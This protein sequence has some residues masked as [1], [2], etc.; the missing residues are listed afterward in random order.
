MMA[1]EPVWWASFL[2]LTSEGSEVESRIHGKNVAASPSAVWLTPR[3]LS[4]V[5][6]FLPRSACARTLRGC[7]KIGDRPKRR[8]TLRLIRKELLVAR[9][10]CPKI[11]S[12]PLTDAPLFFRTDVPRQSSY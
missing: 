9:V 8:P 6:K 10:D 1:R 2:V 5:R 7:E 11:F 12:Q 3:A 4:L